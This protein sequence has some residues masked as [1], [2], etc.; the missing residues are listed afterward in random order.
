[1]ASVGVLRVAGNPEGGIG[2]AGSRRGQRGFD[3]QKG[4]ESL[5]FTILKGGGSPNAKAIESTTSAVMKMRGMSKYFVSLALSPTLLS[6]VQFFS[7]FSDSGNKAG[8]G[9]TELEG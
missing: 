8:K 1:M 5:Q 3:T 9:K 2:S 7:L 4:I 6:P